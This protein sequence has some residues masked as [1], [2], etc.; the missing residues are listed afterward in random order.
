MT[1][2][3]SD[4]VESVKNLTEDEKGEIQLLL[5]QYIREDHREKMLENFESASIQQK[6]EELVFSSDIKELKK[7]IED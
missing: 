1:M 6:R 2:T 3:F 7:L 4:V 5:K